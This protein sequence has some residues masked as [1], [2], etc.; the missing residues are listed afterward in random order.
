MI[1]APK[2]HSAGSNQV[3]VFGHSSDFTV[4]CEGWEF[5]VHRAIL[6]AHS[7]VFRAQ[8][9]A[10]RSR[11]QIECVHPNV[12]QEVFRFMYTGESLDHLAKDLLLISQYLQVEDLKVMCEEA[13]YKNLCINNLAEML[14]LADLYKADELK[15]CTIQFFIRYAADIIKTEAWRAMAIS[16][17]DLADSAFK[18]LT[19]VTEEPQPKA[20][21][22]K[23]T[24]RKYSIEIEVDI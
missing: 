24:K 1:A 10:G 20:R 14:H 8:F 19:R 6:A 5:R 15:R 21:S 13:L 7:R 22:Q 23:R 11:M 12:L 18:A 3:C 2:S 9:E 16:R 4:Y 17:P